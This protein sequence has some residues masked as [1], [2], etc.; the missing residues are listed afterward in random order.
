MSCHV[1]SDHI[2]FD[3]KSMHSV[4]FLIQRHKSCRMVNSLATLGKRELTWRE[5]FQNQFLN[6]IFFLSYHHDDLLKVCIMQNSALI[7]G[8]GEKVNPAESEEKFAKQNSALI[9]QGL[10][11][12]LSQEV[13]SGLEL[14]LTFFAR[15][16]NWI[17]IVAYMQSPGAQV[18]IFCAIS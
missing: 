16:S 11:F 5:I 17:L 15:F 7:P 2:C 14:F 6:L 3:V 18:V 1:A 4:Q 13:P 12:P 10:R 9:P 8:W